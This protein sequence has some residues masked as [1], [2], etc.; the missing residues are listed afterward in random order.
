MSS[1]KH[2]SW[3]SDKNERLQIKKSWKDIV[4]DKHKKNKK[5]KKKI[6]VNKYPE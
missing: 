2:I 1:N 6:I 4:I 3:T 5:N